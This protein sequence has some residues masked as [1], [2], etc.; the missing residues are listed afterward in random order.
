[1]AVPLLGAGKPVPALKDEIRC[2][3][4]ALVGVL[5]EA[6]S[7]TDKVLKTVCLLTSMDDYAVFNEV[8]SEFFGDNSMK[9]ARLCFATSALP[10]GARVEVE[11]TAVL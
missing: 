6:G 3:L 2:A 4:Q 1:M 5:E 11:C 7:G 8:Y 9:P 10:L